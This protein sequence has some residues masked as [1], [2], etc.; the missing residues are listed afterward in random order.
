MQ[1]KLVMPLVFLHELLV[2][3]VVQPTLQADRLRFLARLARMGNAVLGKFMV[4]LYSFAT[5]TPFHL[6]DTKKAPVPASWD[7][8]PSIKPHKTVAFRYTT[9]LRGHALALPS[10][11]GWPITAAIPATSTK[12]RKAFRWGRGSG[13]IFSW[14]RASGSQHAE[15]SVARVVQGTRPLQR[16]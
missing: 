15:L 9:Q 6:T 3:M 1:D 2:D 16:L 4:F 14:A 8:A 12:K 13:V 7:E 5:S 11:L 10:I